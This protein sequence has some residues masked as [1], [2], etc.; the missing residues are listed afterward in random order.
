YLTYAE[1]V[2]DDWFRRAFG[3][4]PGTVWDYVAARTTIEYRAELRQDDLCAV[5]IPTLVKLGTTSVTAEIALRAPDG[6]LAAVVETVV[7]AVDLA[8]R[9]PRPLTADERAALEGATRPRESG[10]AAHR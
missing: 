1:E 7:V 6:R 3:L 10:E 5:G 8:D 2:L 9:R 4:R